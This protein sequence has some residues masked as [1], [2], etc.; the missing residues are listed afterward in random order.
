VQG[1]IYYADLNPVIGSEQN[2]IRPVIIIS[3]DAMNYNFEVCVVCPLTTSKK[4]YPGSV[5]IRPSTFNGLRELSQVLTFQIRTISK[6][7]ILEKVGIL[8]PSQIEEIKKALLDVL[9]Y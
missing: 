7:R 6:K 5:K 2:G 8:E 4:H 3:G 1:S 9:T